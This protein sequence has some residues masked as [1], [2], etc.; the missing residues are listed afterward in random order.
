MSMNRKFMLGLILLALGIFS[1]MTIG[2]AICICW[3]MEIIKQGNIDIYVSKQITREEYETA[4][5]AIIYSVILLAIGVP[6]GIMLIE[7]AITE[8]EWK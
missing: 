8:W 1:A 5:M 2:Y 4:I 6:F 3:H 7:E